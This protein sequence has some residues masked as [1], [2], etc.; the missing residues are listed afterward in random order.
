MHFDL[1]DVVVLLRQ[2][3]HIFN[4]LPSDRAPMPLAGAQ[5]GHDICPE[6]RFPPTFHLASVDHPSPPTHSQRCQKPLHLHVSM[7][8]FELAERPRAARD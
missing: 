6:Q 4:F 7:P 3:E 2:T 5:V 8:D 1:D